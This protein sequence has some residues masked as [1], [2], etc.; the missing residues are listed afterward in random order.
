MAMITFKAKKKKH[1]SEDYYYVQLPVLTRAHCDM[2]AIR[3]HPKI[4]AYANSDL[5]AAVLARET[6][7]IPSLIRLDAPPAGVT[8]KDGFLTTI[9]F[10]I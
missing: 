3:Q 1:W 5:F 9:S 8:V 10:N 6:K 2:N 7:H 4:G